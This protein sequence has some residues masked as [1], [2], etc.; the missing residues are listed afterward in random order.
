MNQKKQL[1]LFVFSSFVLALLAYFVIDLPLAIYFRAGRG[2][3]FYDVMENISKLGESH[4]YI[5]VFFVGWVYFR[6]KDVI[7]SFYCKF[8]LYCVLFSG[9][10]RVF[11]KT[12]IARFRPSMY[13]R[14]GSYGFADGF[15]FNDYLYNSMPSG[16][17]TTAFS[18]GMGL[19]LLFPKYKVLFLL[20][21]FLI[22]FTRVAT[23]VHYVSDTIFGMVLGVLSSLFVY[24][25]LTTNAYF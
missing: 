9:A 5:V 25:K 6:K 24:K 2:S 23:A 12:T 1:V 10:I 8:L 4:W 13:F 16:H 11:L 17:T 15:Y 18:I 21:G 3:I 7:K 20:F 14:D 19:A 22:G